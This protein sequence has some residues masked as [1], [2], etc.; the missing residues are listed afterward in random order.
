MDALGF[1]G[2]VSWSAIPVI[3]Y[4]LSRGEG[5]SM[6]R[7]CAINKTRFAHPPSPAVQFDLSANP[8]DPAPRMTTPHDSRSQS[9]QSPKTYSSQKLYSAPLRPLGVSRLAAFQ[10]AYNHGRGT[11]AR[12]GQCQRHKR[13]RECM[14]RTRYLASCTRTPAAPLRTTRLP[15]DVPRR[16]WSEAAHDASLIRRRA[17][18][19]AYARVHLPLLFSLAPR[20]R[21]PSSLH[22]TS[23]RCFQNDITSS[24]VQT[25]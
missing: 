25:R 16:W 20:R 2:R 24:R 5:E 23:L 9:M 3:V 18:A 19:D 7:G 13:G 12:K 6:G 8:T 14:A 22:L 21:L 17:T 4:I 15:S 10:P 1:S 11:S